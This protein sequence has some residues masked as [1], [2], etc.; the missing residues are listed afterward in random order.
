MPVS[1]SKN[2]RR[3]YSSGSVNKIAANRPAI[4][5]LAEAIEQ[6]D[7]YASLAEVAIRYNYKRPD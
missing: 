2:W 3:N 4:L 1:A 7:V 6:I 5:A